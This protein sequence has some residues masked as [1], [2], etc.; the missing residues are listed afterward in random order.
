MD[1]LGLALESFDAV[2]HRRTVR[3]NSTEPIDVSGVM[4]GGAAFEGAA[5]LREILVS[6]SA[7]FLQTLSEKLLTYALG[8]GVEY[9]DMP[10]VRGILRD[11]AATDYSFSSIV[12]GIVRSAPF[13][14]RRVSEPDSAALAQQ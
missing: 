9:Y 3:G 1:P 2:G 11:A 5:G 14:L 8:R 7:Q 13:Q 10:A 12:M 4:P 6:R